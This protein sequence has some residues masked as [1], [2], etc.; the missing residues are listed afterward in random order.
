MSCYKLLRPLLFLFPEECSHDLSI[1][2]F[3]YLALSK[4]REF[5]NI[6]RNDVLDMHFT[7]PIGLAA[8][9]DKNAQIFSKLY[10]YNFGFI[11]CGTV[12]PKAQSGNSKP[13]LFRLKEDE[14]IINR[15][16]FNN[17]GMEEFAQNIKGGKKHIPAEFPIGINIGK[18][19]LQE[20][21]LSDYLTLIEKFYPLANYLTI[22][23]S[24]PNT[25]NLRDIQSR[26]N[27]E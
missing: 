4:R 23:I 15:F 16:G 2:Y 8:G 6:L 26:D 17:V 19:K 20:D 7:N 27:L 13:R 18:N 12:T 3:K 5:S 9:Y 22:N 10:S 24:S 21:F 14:A 11:E 1:L 25:P